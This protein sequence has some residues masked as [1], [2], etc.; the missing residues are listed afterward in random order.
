[1]NRQLRMLKSKI[2]R[3]TVTETNL[4]YEGSL[5][6]DPVLMEAAGIFQW[7]ELHIWD[8]TNGARISTYAISGEP[9][10]G[11]ICIN[12]AAA[13]LVNRG[14]VIII[15]TFVLVDEAEARKHSPRIVFVDAG[16]QA[17]TP[18]NLIR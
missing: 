3:A 1:M 12:G 7:E 8:V 14:D 18:G 4:E 13:H 10:S 17:I 16:N 15:A 2:H 6:I 9:G 11:T 5:T